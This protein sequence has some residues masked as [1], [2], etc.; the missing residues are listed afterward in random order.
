MLEASIKLNSKTDLLNLVKYIGDANASPGESYVQ[1]L[2]TEAIVRLV[3]KIS[4]NDTTI[5]RISLKNLFL[6]KVTRVWL[7]I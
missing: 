3:L 6:L 5:I 7:E 1:V 4:K 2:Q